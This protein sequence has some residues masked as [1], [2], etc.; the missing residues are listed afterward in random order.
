MIQRTDGLGFS[1][2]LLYEPRIF[3]QSHRKHFDRHATAHEKVLAEIDRAHAT[4]A[5]TLENPVLSEREASPPALQKL[6]GL[7]TSQ[8]AVADEAPGQCL[9]FAGHNRCRA[10]LR[11]IGI[12]VLG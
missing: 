10:E 7:E 9:R 5:E 2:E 11:K 8:H 4:G 6:L 1:V 12:K 3:R